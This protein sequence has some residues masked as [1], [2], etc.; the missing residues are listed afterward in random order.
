MRH[1]AGGTS[2]ITESQLLHRSPFSNQPTNG[3]RPVR[4]NTQGSNF[5]VRVRHP[6]SH[7]LSVGIQTNQSYFIHG[8]DSPFACGS[9]P[10]VS[11]NSQRN[12]RTARWKSVFVFSM[13][14]PT[15]L[16]SVRPL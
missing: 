3:L 8:T 15:E 5:T 2:S 10:L 11:N 1:V 6:D 14:R 7:G 16:E 4:D 13:A 9:A 12:P